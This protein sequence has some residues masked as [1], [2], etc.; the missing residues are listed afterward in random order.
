MHVDDA[1]ARLRA[2]PRD[3]YARARRE[4]VPL[5]LAALAAGV[6][7]QLARLIHSQPIFAPIA[8]LVSL[9]A[10]VGQRG[11][12]AVHMIVGITLGV[13]LA[14]LL[15]R[16]IGYGAWELGV[17][18]LVAMLV[19]SALGVP[20]LAVTQVGVWC[21]LVIALGPHSGSFALGRFVDGL[22]GGGVALVL[23]RVV[24]PADPHRLVADAARPLYEELASIIDELATALEQRDE[25]R[26]RRALR[27]AD[28]I[29]DRPLREAV[30][31]AREV[32]RRAPRRRSRRAWIE[33]YAR[34]ADELDTIERNLN[35][36]ALA[37]VR[38]T[39]E[40]QTP[41]PFADAMHRLALAYRA[42]PERLGPSEADPVEPALAEV[43]AT[44]ARYDGDA[45]LSGSVLRQQL[46]AL[47]RDARR[48]LEPNS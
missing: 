6:A 29:D 28:R 14:E 1:L 43:E 18:A 7:Y 19:A 11:Q 48:A 42:L 20:R 10:N 5:A 31:T 37:S 33:P 16:A 12:Q 47:V 27:R 34:A 36:L 13:L 21:I 25:E 46:E 26:A 8:A 35:V 3:G 44:L 38:Q 39:R 24:F 40:A 9:R 41:R 22:I 30:Q 15:G 4:L 45:G 17:S 32:A 23:V 2:L